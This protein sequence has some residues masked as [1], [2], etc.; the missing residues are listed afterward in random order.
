MRI[1]KYIAC[2]MMVFLIGASL[3]VYAQE[4]N[5]A[6][7]QDI[8]IDGEEPENNDSENEK[9]D[10][11][12][13]VL[14]EDSAG[15]KEE[16]IVNSNQDN[17]LNEGNGEVSEENKQESERQEE[18]TL[19][20]PETDAFAELTEISV[21][22]GWYAVQAFDNKG[23]CLD[24]INSSDK[25]GAEI[26]LYKSV[27]TL[28]QRFLIER[29]ENGWYTIQNISSNKYLG[30]EGGI[31]EDQEETVYEVLQ[32]TGNG[33][34]AQEFKFYQD[35]KGTVIIQVHEGEKLV[36]DT[37]AVG[38]GKRLKASAYGEKSSQKFSLR[39]EKTPG[40]E[41]DIE[42]GT[43][44]IYP[45]QASGVSLDL[46]DASHKKGA[47]IQLYTA[48]GTSAQEWKISKQG[49]WYK[50]TSAE[51]SMVLDVAGG[52]SGAGTNLQQWTSNSGKG[53]FFRFYQTGDGQYCIMSKLGTV[54]DC[55]GGSTKSK[56][57]VQ[58]YTVNGTAAQTWSLEKIL[59]P[60]KSEKKLGNGYYT[61]ASGGNT[62]LRMGVEGESNDKGVKIQLQAA[63]ESDSQI[64]KIESQS[65]GW[66]MFKNLKSGKYLDVRGGK[67]EP[68]TILQQ[69]T[70][71]N[72]AAQKFKLCDAGNGQYYIKSKLSLIVESVQQENGDVY[73]DHASCGADQKWVIKKTYSEGNVVSVANGDYIISSGLGN[74]QVLDI[75]SGS[76]SSGANVQI[77]KNNK[78]MAQ[79]FHIHKESDGWYTI[80]N[81][82]SKKYLDV[83]SASGEP[84]ANLQQYNGNKTDA[85]KFKFYDSGD[86]KY[87]IKSKLGTFVDV[88]D[89]KSASGT[90]VQMYTFNG[91]NAQKWTLTKSKR[92]P[93]NEWVYKNG[94]KYYYNG[95]GNLV[96]DVSGIIGK[97]SSYV[98]KVNKKRNVVTVYA[99]DGKNGYIIPV[100]S[101]ICSTGAA[102]PSGTFYTP[103][104]YRWHTLMGP[105][106]GQWCTRIH[107]GV[108]FHSVF[109]SSMKNTTLSVNAYN[110]LGITCSHGCVRLTAGDAKWIYDNCKLK[111]KVIVYSSDNAGPFGKPTAYKLPSWHKWDPTDPNVKSKCRKKG[112]H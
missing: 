54:I 46:W 27:F 44:R 31:P 68:N 2:I 4:K 59:I 51:S 86:G 87:Y 97:Q 50:I 103:A 99:K 18:E 53:Q 55:K 33:S 49:S 56:T 60:A 20:T 11:E 26:Q 22:D 3:P 90:N 65:D 105:C 74:S 21:S 12:N 109:Y 89:A 13:D 93:M 17:E 62:N 15:D 6:S 81:N 23:L 73:I 29:K 106:Y 30:V 45:S 75:K 100:K 66:Y 94:Y 35:E 78:S 63:K 112:C 24:V 39:Q 83:K 79:N 41:V 72:V 69:Y 34:E 84:K 108:L 71:A 82:K 77:Y 52:K 64:F 19:A 5:D 36:L 70:K 40:M 102:T 58:M 42:E 76:T 7:S 38:T 101:F 61:I 9:S 10:V 1:R 98:I 14:L 25:D 91:C 111:T 104:K 110:K 48:N 47:N 67:K 96:K 32:W 8:I 57:N 107:G 95:S 16:S 37:E 43:Y 85:Q 88:T 92:T 28:A 80:Q